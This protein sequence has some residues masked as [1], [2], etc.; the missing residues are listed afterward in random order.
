[1]NKI[2]KNSIF[3]M[4]SL[5]CS[6]TLISC[7]GGDGDTPLTN[8]QIRDLKVV[9]YNTLISGERIEYL[10]LA[11]N[12]LEDGLRFES[13]NTT[14]G[15][16]TFGRIYEYNNDV[17]DE[18]SFQLKGS[19][20]EGNA[21]ARD[22][23]QNAVDNLIGLGSSGV[24]GNTDFIAMIRGDVPMD[25]VEI[26]RLLNDQGGGT[27]LISGNLFADGPVFYDNLITSTYDAIFK[28]Q[29]IEGLYN[30]YNTKRAI[31]FDNATE[32]ERNKLDP[33]NLNPGVVI[34]YTIPRIEEDLSDNLINL[35]ADGSATLEV[36]GGRFRL[37][38]L[39]QN[40][41]R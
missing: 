8:D 31:F 9:A 38:L 11:S 23:L 16:N 29:V 35:L 13:P 34:N 36:E 4:L 2:T 21:S 5:F 27:E 26:S 41:D 32:R 6:L 22:R 20:T 24:D 10:E 33:N 37:F 18:Q 3:S 39:N 14:T 7:D 25:L 12:A 15:I 30:R 40:T 1:M 28:A 17:G 19:G